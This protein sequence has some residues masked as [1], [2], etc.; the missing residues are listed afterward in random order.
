MQPEKPEYFLFK[1]VYDGNQP[2]FYNPEEFEWVKELEQHWKVVLEEMG[3][4][5]GHAAEFENNSYYPPNLSSPTAW[6]NIVFYN[7]C[8][9]NNTN[10]KRFPK[11]DALLNNIPNLTYAALCLL[12]PQSSVL[13][14]Y[15]D[16]NTT[17][18]CHLGIKVPA[19]LPECGIRVGNEEQPWRE[20]K[21]LMFCDAQKHTTWNKTD[22]RRYVF[23]IDVMRQE[24]AD[25]KLSVCSKVLAVFTLKYFDQRIAFIKKAPRFLVEILHT[26]LGWGWLVFLT[27]QRIV[28]K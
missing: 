22:Q 13:P 8:W 18:R 1:E 10:R 23:T 25:Q 7:Y 27:A 2:C 17:M 5:I 24:Y 26:C 21:L 14:H 15:G 16:T 12:E 11:T 20:G 4:L 19:G 9:Q 6:K 3:H 28:Y